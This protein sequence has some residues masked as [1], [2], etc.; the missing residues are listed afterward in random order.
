MLV[1]WQVVKVRRFRFR[2]LI[3]LDGT[4]PHPRLPRKGRREYPNHTR[5]LMVEARPLRG[6][7]CTRHFT[8]ELCWDSEQPLHPGDRA[9]VTITVTDDEARAFFDAGQR[10]TIWSG[11]GVGHGVVSRRVFTDN[12]PS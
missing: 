4:E 9:E 5:D 12:S 8:A 1:G 10:F 2:A 6:A 3:T 7:G 11:G